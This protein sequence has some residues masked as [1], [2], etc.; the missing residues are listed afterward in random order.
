M[1]RASVLGHCPVSIKAVLIR[2]ERKLLRSC[3]F[4]KKPVVQGVFLSCASGA[5]GR[6]DNL[7]VE[8]SDK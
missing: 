8:A 4:F 7:M 6:I 3:T 1:V 5:A 2:L